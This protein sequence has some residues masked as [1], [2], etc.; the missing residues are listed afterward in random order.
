L[1]KADVTK[2]LC[3]GYVQ[4]NTHDVA[5]L[6]GDGRGLPASALVTSDNSGS[7]AFRF[8]WRDAGKLKHA[9][10][11]VFS[12][13]CSSGFSHI[14]GVGDRLGLMAGLQSAGTRSFVAPRWDIVAEDVLPI[15]DDALERFCKDGELAKSVADACAAA[16]LDTPDWVRWAIA[17]EGDWR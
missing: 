16:P 3:H 10:S 17:I 15:L 14:A 2:V 1:T 9:A 4:S 5:W 6:I 8:G 12:A 13:A 11:A 7:A